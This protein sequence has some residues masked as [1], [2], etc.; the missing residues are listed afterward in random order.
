MKQRGLQNVATFGFCS[1]PSTS[2]SCDA[3]VHIGYLKSNF[4]VSFGCQ[5]V[6][7]SQRSNP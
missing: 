1:L 5:S 2:A 7:V 6:G 4:M 3:T